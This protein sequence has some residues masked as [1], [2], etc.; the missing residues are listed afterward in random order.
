MI[1]KNKTSVQ[2]LKYIIVGGIASLVDIAV[3]YA[4]ISVLEINYIIANTFSILAGLFVNYYLS[5]EW[6]FNHKKHRFI[7]DFGLFALVGLIGLGLSN[8]LLYVLV[9]LKILSKI[10]FFLK[11][12]SIKVVAKLIVMIIVLFWNYIARK[13]FVFNNETEKSK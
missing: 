12:K 2:F 1:F 9:D 3:Y 11:D 8:V 13:K 6:V 10:A 4:G 5:R 7:R